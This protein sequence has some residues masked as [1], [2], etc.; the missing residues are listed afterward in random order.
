MQVQPAPF[1]Q[2]A[3]IAGVAS[4]V[5]SMSNERPYSGVRTSPTFETEN[6]SNLSNLREFENGPR[7]APRMPLFSLSDSI[8]DPFAPDEAS[9][10]RYSD[11]SMLARQAPPPLPLV[12]TTTQLPV[13]AP[14]PIGGVR[15]FV[16]RDGQ[17]IEVDANMQPIGQ[18]L[19]IVSQGVAQ[20]PAVRT[21]QPAMT[22]TPVVVSPPAPQIVT[23]TTTTTQAI[24]QPQGPASGRVSYS[25]NLDTVRSCQ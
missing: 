9:I 21:A 5:R 8:N 13:A 15:K 25:K 14:N 6:R 12:T 24:T 1:P 4:A 16:I 19:P 17:R 2:G 10:L 20:A 18:G 3:A 11:T 22:T 7:D 23:Q